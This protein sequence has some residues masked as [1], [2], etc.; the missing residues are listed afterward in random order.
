MI[1][2]ELGIATNIV[3]IVQKE[4]SL[5]RYGRIATIALRIGAMTD[6]DHESLR[7]GFE[8]I[9][10][11]TPLEH[12]NLKIEAVPISVHCE[13]CARDSEI[14]RYQFV[15]PTCGSRNVALQHGTE[16]DIAYLEVDDGS[17]DLSPHKKQEASND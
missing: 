11:N 16:L 17:E 7:F 6:V 12:T 2:H 15:C 13:A 9:T 10:R 5:H 3:E 14:E 4:I 1:M 8:V